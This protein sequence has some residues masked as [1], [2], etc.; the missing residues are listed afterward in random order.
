VRNPD[1]KNTSITIN[2]EALPTRTCAI[3]TTSPAWGPTRGGY[4]AW[5]YDQ[6]NRIFTPAI[7]H[8]S[9]MQNLLINVAA[10]LHDTTDKE[11]TLGHLE[12]AVRQLKKQIK[13]EAD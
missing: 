3:T 13:D 10:F 11:V 12:A 6:R 8:Y 2:L 9:N 5:Y 1:P 7:H 4:A